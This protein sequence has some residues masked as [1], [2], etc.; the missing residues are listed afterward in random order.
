MMAMM[1]M[2]VHFFSEQQNGEQANHHKDFLF[3]HAHNFHL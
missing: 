3:T 2:V 1:I